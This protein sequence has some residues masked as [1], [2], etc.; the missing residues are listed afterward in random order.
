M[1]NLSI[2]TVDKEKG[3]E[4]NIHSCTQADTGES[5]FNGVHS[6][7]QGMMFSITFICDPGGEISKNDGR[8]E[9]NN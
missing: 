7:M 1:K 2:G 6:E 8:E 4:K 5:N 3:V 9:K